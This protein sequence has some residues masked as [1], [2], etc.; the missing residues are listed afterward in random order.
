MY[1]GIPQLYRL[2]FGV[3]V[4]HED[5]PISLTNH[6]VIKETKENEK[7][8]KDLDVV[9]RHSFPT[10]F[11]VLKF[12]P[13]STRSQFGNNLHISIVI[14]NHRQPKNLGLKDYW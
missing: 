14:A 6:R 5:T 9:G 8:G 11:P 7:V 4:W 10:F 1:S 2:G 12:H 3:V 13:K